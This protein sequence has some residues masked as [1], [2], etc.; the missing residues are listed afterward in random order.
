MD[1]IAVASSTIAAIA[2]SDATSTLEVAFHNGSAYEYYGV[3]RNLFE[4]L[5]TAPS[6][7]RYLNAYI[8]KGGFAYR[9]I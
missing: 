5:R 8:V 2:Y 6:A 7:G 1:R 4:G 3:P 9:R